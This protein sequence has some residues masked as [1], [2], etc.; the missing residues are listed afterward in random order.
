MRGPLGPRLLLGPSPVRFTSRPNGAGSASRQLEVTSRGVGHE[1]C[2]RGLRRAARAPGAGGA[3]APP[4][5]G[6]SA[7]CAGCSYID[8]SAQGGF[9]HRAKRGRARARST[10]HHHHLRDH[11]VGT[12]VTHG[13]SGWHW[14]PGPSSHVTLVC[15]IWF[16]GSSLWPLAQL[17]VGPS[18]FGLGAGFPPARSWRASHVQG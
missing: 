2:G 11:R 5:L 18:T 9:P 17:Y 6:L 15:A 10:H 13:P 12:G 7:G 8:P 3:T 1:W 16:G 14:A 4:L